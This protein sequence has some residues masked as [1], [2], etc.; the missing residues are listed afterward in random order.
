VC[1]SVC[2]CLCV[3]VCVSVCVCQ[4]AMLYRSDSV[5]YR[6]Q[7]PDMDSGIEAGSDIA[8]PT[9]SFPISPPTPYG[10]CVTVAMDRPT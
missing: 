3:C 5:D 1:V 10:E 6:A 2:V 8:P 9:P 7:G 4:H